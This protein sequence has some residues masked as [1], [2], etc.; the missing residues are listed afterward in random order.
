[1]IKRNC[2]LVVMI[3]KVASLVANVYVAVQTTVWLANDF[4]FTGEDF[5]AD[6]S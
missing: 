1:M 5:D 4:K 6:F 3:N 2:Q